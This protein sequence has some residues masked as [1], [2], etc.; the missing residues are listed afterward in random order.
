MNRVS[1]R[2]ANNNM[3]D[4]SES[5]NFKFID[6]LKSTGFIPYAGD[7]STC[8][9]E[10]E[11]QTVVSGKSSD[12]DLA[13]YISESNY[14]KNLVKRVSRGDA[15]S[16]RLEGLMEYL[17]N[18]EKGIWENSWVR[19]PRNTLSAYAESVFQ[20]DLKQDKSSP[21]GPDRK[22]SATFLTHENGKEMI[23]I[24]VSYLLKLA[25]ADTLDSRTYIHPVVRSTGIK[26]LESF[27]NDNTSP[28]IVSFFPVKGVG[29]T[30]P[31]VNI[32]NQ[33]LKSYLLTQLLIMYSNKKFELSMN[34]QDVSLYFS[35]HPPV[36]QK[37][38]NDLIPDSFYRELFMSPCLSGWDRGEEKHSY[39]NLCH[40]VLSRS[41][42]NSILKLKEAGIVSGNRVYLKG[43]SNIS[44]ANNGTHISIGSR[45]LSEMMRSDSSLCTPLHEK[46]Y[47]DLAIKIAEHFIPL[48]T[49]TYSASPYRLGFHDFNP[50]KVLGFLSHELDFTQLR[51]LWSVWQNKA[52]LKIFGNPVLPSEPEWLGRYMVRL[53]GLRGDYINDYRMID[54]PV[55]LMS[56]DESPLFNGRPGND[57]RLKK[58]LASMGVFDSKMSVYTL[59]RMRSMA[60]AG[61]TGFEGRYYSLFENLEND[62]GKA[63]D[64]QI[65]ITAL[66]WKYIIHDGVDHGHIPDTPETES[67][68]R[69]VVF[70][71][72]IG[73]PVFY[74]KKNSRCA[75]MGRIIARTANVQASSRYPG[76]H[77]IRT[78]D[79]LR[80]LVD[81]IKADSGDLAE[82]MNLREIISDLEQRIENPDEN[83]AL[84]RLTEGIL[85]KAGAR[86]PLGISADEFNLCAEEYYRVELR[87][88]HIGEALD[89]LFMEL[90]SIDRGSVKLDPGAR[91][92][93][94]SVLSTR[95]ASGFIRSMKHQ[96]LRGDLPLLY[97]VSMIQ[98]L[99][100]LLYNDMKNF[101]AAG[102]SD[103]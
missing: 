82:S 44:L 58:D 33:T 53:F 46:Y 45:K 92:A 57:E 93:L 30:G 18:N 79:Y 11:F 1:E 100:V 72:S 64:L 81:T 78:Q 83:S 27:L 73:L 32:T 51:M 43:I 65:L 2:T 15:G 86:S 67:E 9:I 71:S 103:K 25:L 61:F 4:F 39:M 12:I 80:A 22:D 50:E 101:S 13:R 31:A 59:Y 99:L 91:A 8:G 38:L 28:E 98:L 62:M 85:K 88:K 90:E 47:G 54:F 35:P 26:F 74:V 60:N 89:L 24:P 19:F 14:L 49:G 97:I 102:E 94:Q 17:D 36:R 95:S 23:R 68:R 75:F 76:Y 5:I 63:A 29:G 6:S 55:S 34:G 69:Q 70:A 52:N 77:E 21:S 37:R 3:N 20:H 84:G 41:N 56:T 48:F 40:Q 87:E 7:D 42:L 10:N 16:K 66:A 96:V